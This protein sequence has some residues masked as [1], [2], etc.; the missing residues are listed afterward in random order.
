MDALFLPGVPEKPIR[1]MYAAAPGNEIASGRFASP[2]SSAALA[3]NTFGF[4][5]NRPGDL[6]LPPEWA[7]GP[8]LSLSF[9]TEVRFPW[10]GGRHPWLDAI[11]KTSSAI[12]GVEAKR[13]EPFRGK[14]RSKF[15]SAY[16]RPVWGD[17]MKGYE[18]VR[19]ALH[20]NRVQCSHFDAAQLVKHA[21]ALRTEAQRLSG[22][23]PLL[24]YLYA[25][26]DHWPVTDKP[27]GQ[28]D[29]LAHRKEIAHF[30]EQV[31]GDEVRFLSCSYRELLAWWARNSKP[32]VRAH[33]NTVIQRFS[34]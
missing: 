4:F 23:R 7:E 30:A 33:A 10:S 25:E 9:E 3:A 18:S 28:V 15:S 24:V 27:V 12:I 26:P 21:F 8:A 16:W 5:L 19:D 14:S 1:D 31:A 2:E 6:P 34:P 32:D 11:V 29:I 22:F 17:R 13:F 20:E